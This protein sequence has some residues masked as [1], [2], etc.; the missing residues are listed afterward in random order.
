MNSLK[1]RLTVSALLVILFI[2]PVIGI[3]LNN[4]FEEHIKTSIKNELI[5]YS[6]SILAVAEV[7]QKQ[8]L[9][10]EQ[11]LQTRFNVI[12]SG[13]YALI[14]KASSKIIN[15]PH[16]VNQANLWSSPSTLSLNLSDKLLSPAVGDAKFY[17][18]IHE[19]NRY[20]VYTLTVS[21]NDSIQPYAISLSI[22]NDS[23][24]FIKSTLQFKN[25]LWLW[26]LILALLL[27][28]V[29]IIWLLWT[30]KPLK[31]LKAEL[32]AIEAGDTLQLEESYPKEL[33]QV[34]QQVNLLLKTEQN[35]RK[36]HRNALADLTHS[37]KTP[38]AVIQSGD[39]LTINQL[40]Q[41]SLINKT[42]EHQLK[43]AQ[44][45][46]E[47]S[48][49]LGCKVLPVVDKLISAFKKIYHDN[50]IQFISNIPST[51][52]FKGDESDLMEVLGNLI[53]NACKAAKNVVDIEVT[54]KGSLLLIK[55]EDDGEGVPLDVRDLIINRGTRAD[56]Y[57]KGHGIGLAIVHDIVT[58]YQGIVLIERSDKLGGAKFTLQFN[59]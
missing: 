29:Q 21:F 50:N 36:R 6:Y 31:I 32:S 54:L 2:L 15:G 19:T 44:S 22:V 49:H 8:I 23:N 57:Q 28:V 58:S 9:M 41:L 56:S 42:I 38:L 3:T 20:F 16:T 27:I 4:A 7:E 17:E 10:P 13:L 55:V 52:D 12:D 26:L 39:N 35:Q 34:T 25:Q 45:A 18:V 46:G 59:Q 5:A 37:L 33:E 51:V 48:W 1:T 40:E 11:L 43:R 30:L 14:H 47:S 24:D 53:D